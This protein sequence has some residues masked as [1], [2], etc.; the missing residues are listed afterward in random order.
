VAQAAYT[1]EIKPLDLVKELIEQ[2]E[3]H[4]NLDTL[5]LDSA[6]SSTSVIS[7]LKEKGIDFI[8][9]LK[10]HGGDLKGILAQITGLHDDFENFIRELSASSISESVRVVSQ[11]DWKHAIKEVLNRSVDTQQSSLENF[12]EMGDARVPDPDD[13]PA[14]L[15][16]SRRPYAT[17]IDGRTAEEVIGRYKYRWRVENFYAAKKSKL[18][19]KIQSREHGIRVFLSG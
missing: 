3:K 5:T 15:W 16:K 11:L 2:A 18:L 8:M 4:C 10:R 9:R 12:N 14:L 1:P 6:F 7:Y 17:N 13:L 19:A